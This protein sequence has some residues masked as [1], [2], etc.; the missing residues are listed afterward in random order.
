MDENQTKSSN[1]STKVDRSLYPK[2]A[3]FP[4]EDDGGRTRG[5]Y[6]AGLPKN[7]NKVNATS[8]QNSSTVVSKPN[9]KASNASKKVNT[10]SNKTE[11]HLFNTASNKVNTTSN[12]ANNASNK[13][14]SS[15]ISH[16]ANN[17][18]N[19]VSSLKSKEASSSRSNA[20][21]VKK[22]GETKNNTS[23]LKNATS[24]LKTQ[25]GILVLNQITDE[26]NFNLTTNTKEK[27]KNTVKPG[28][29]WHIW[30][31][32]QE[33]KKQM[34]LNKSL[35]NKPQNQVQNAGKNM[36]KAN[37]SNGNLKSFKIEDYKEKKEIPDLGKSNLRI[38]FIGGIGEIGKNM[39]LF[40]YGNDMIMVDAGQ[41]FPD[42]TLPGVD[43][44]VQDLTYL[45]A[46]KSKLRGIFI[47][48]GHEDHIG[49]IL[50]VLKIATPPIY[51]SGVSLGLIDGKLRDAR[52]KMENLVLKAVKAGSSVNAGDF[53]VEFVSVTHSIPGAFGLAITTPI[54]TVFHTGD[55]KIDGTPMG[56]DFCDLKRIAEI[57]RK[58]I[59]LLMSDSTNVERQGFSLSE[60]V[61]YK[62]FKNIFESHKQERLIIATFAS[63]IRRLQTVIDLAKAYNRKVAFT[64]RSMLTVS[65]M[66][67]KLG[68][69]KFDKEVIIDIDK[70]DRYQDKELV[71]ISTGSQGEVMS[72]LSRIS[73]DDFPKVRLGENDLVVLSS[74]PIPGNERD[75][76]N[77][78]NQLYRKNC[79][80]ITN[81][82]MQVHASGHA[83]KEELKIM[84]SLAHP[85]FFVPVHGEYRHL[86]NQQMVAKEYGLNDR[87][88]I[89]PELG[90]QL[91]LGPN[92]IKVAGRVPAGDILVDGTARGEKESD[93]IRDRL[94]LSKAGVC[95]ASIFLNKKSKRII[96][97]PSFK[98]RGFVYRNE[99]R[100]VLG[101]AQK[102]LFN[103]FKKVDFKTFGSQKEIEHYVK[104]TITN[105]FTKR[106][107][108]RPFVIPVIV[109]V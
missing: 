58:G 31:K 27:T 109:E 33:K 44:V 20:N 54:G 64:G 8:R 83:Y 2:G 69:I 7:Y 35:S 73:L 24:K 9:H 108:R 28:Q 22:V 37:V 92:F 72:A 14:S 79:K 96:M 57:G 62:T 70:V 94:S 46:N 80:I 61:V 47:T 97:P 43:S 71:I 103:E 67:M 39:T 90:M 34:L 4:P 63:N 99:A 106:T 32:R 59:L 19:K 91:E 107:K 30:K 15:T 68:E 12:K 25:N 5:V 18:K 87:N 85:T 65:E 93:V 74:S 101:V 56:G 60:A 49:G 45:E 6:H 75:V 76:N 84:L 52:F 50:E 48:H 53:T 66:A 1:V 77:L 82:N 38:T 98:A 36:P 3:W 86:K 11:S 105:Y 51:G 41:S 13:V 81:D 23:S 102:N 10:G 21:L 104:K 55:F 95:V 89:I 42:E 40:E 88:I 78:I 17:A 29:E 100:L 16:R 26:N